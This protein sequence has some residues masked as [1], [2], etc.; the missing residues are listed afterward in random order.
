MAQHPEGRHRL[1]AQ[2]VQAKPLAR[3]A[4]AIP[5]S[6]RNRAELD[7]REA[8]RSAIPQFIPKI[9]AH[10]DQNPPTPSDGSSKNPRSQAIRTYER[11]P[12]KQVFTLF[13]TV[14][15]GRSRILPWPMSLCEGPEAAVSR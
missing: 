7:A 8:V 4:D 12:P 13:E 1:R 11:L 14:R 2:S 3:H 6:F 10:D 9:A 15:F 5:N